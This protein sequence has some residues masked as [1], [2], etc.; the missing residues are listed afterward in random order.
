MAKFQFLKSSSSGVLSGF[1]AAAALSLSSSFSAYSFAQD[2]D[3]NHTTD[4]ASQITENGPDK[5]AIRLVEADDV[6]Y[7]NHFHLAYIQ[8]SSSAMNSIIER[9]MTALKDKLIEATNVEPAGVVGLDPEQDELSYFRVIY[10]PV[11]N[12][13]NRLSDQARQ[14]IQDYINGGGVILF[15][16]Q[17]GDFT[18]L[19]RLLNEFGTRPLVPLDSEHSLNKS[20]YLLPNLPGHS[21][22]GTVW[23]ERS[24]NQGQERPSSVIIGSRNW[25]LAWAG[26]PGNENSRERELALRSGANLVLYALTGDYK[27]DQVH[28]PAIIERLGLD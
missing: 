26:T 8:T 17:G 11:M 10:W 7:I 27:S 14:K 18:L 25:A 13:A 3:S 16:V 15:D 19:R 2:H 24:D 12:D 20:F 28:A 6:K 23:V 21:N 1:L 4:T 5:S 9:G 22:Y